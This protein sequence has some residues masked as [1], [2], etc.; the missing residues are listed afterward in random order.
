MLIIFVSLLLFATVLVR[1][2][3]LGLYVVTGCATLI[4]QESLFAPVGTDR[5]NV[6]NWPL[7][8]Q[9]MPERPIGLLF[10]FLLL[11]IACYR[12]SRGQSPLRFGRLSLVFLFYLVC[13]AIGIVHGLAHGGNL[14][15]IVVEVRPFWYLFLSYLLAYNFVRARHH[16]YTFFWLVIASAGI[17]SLQALYLYIFVL[18]GNLQGHHELMAHEESFFFAG[19]LLLLLLF[20]L[21]SRYR[22]Q[23]YTMLLI[24][25]SV[26]IALVVN[27]RRADY[28]AL[29]VGGVV[30]WSLTFSCKPHSRRAL[31]LGMCGCILL[32]TSYISICSGLT[33]PFAA[34]AHA[35]VS[36]FCPD[37]TDRVSA[38]SNAYRATEDYDL[39]YTVQKSPLL[40]WGFG[41]QFLEPLVLPNI[42]SLDAN[43]LYIP[44][45][46]IYWVWMRLGI[47]GF[48]A[49]GCLFGSIIVKGYLAAR[50]CHDPY[51]Q[52]V[53]IYV[54]AITCMEIVVAFADYQLFAYRNVIFLGLLAG[55]LL[56]LPVLVREKGAS[57]L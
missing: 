1:W 46:T 50:Q 43:Y 33:G 48:T 41:R 2:P 18:H 45:N 17:K 13:V 5:L 7:P 49:L 31:A 36:V 39:L 30:A 47:V 4:E 27:Q 14:K 19:L 44:H 35:I 38:E 26:L 11:L 15:I 55:L 29:I 34:P 40:G 6:Y 21:H 54:V 3:I 32:S 28:L 10:I 12:L 42:S 24:L 22:S 20:C 16:V 56:K 9:G 23:F 51:L 37:T 53:A 25:P 57:C 8:L 52:L